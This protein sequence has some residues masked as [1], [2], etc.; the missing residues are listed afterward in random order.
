MLISNYLSTCT[1]ISVCLSMHFHLPFIPYFTIVTL[2]VFG[3]QTKTYT[4]IHKERMKRPYFALQ[5]LLLKK[6]SGLLKLS[7]A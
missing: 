3:F 7:S 4:D 6:H 5:V 1:S 2:L